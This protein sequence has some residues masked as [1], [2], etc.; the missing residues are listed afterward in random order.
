[1]NF[2]ISSPIIL[3]TKQGDWLHIALESSSGYEHSVFLYDEDLQGADLLPEDLFKRWQERSSEIKNLLLRIHSSCRFGDVFGGLSCDCGE[4]LRVAKE[5]IVSNK[6]GAI[7]YLDQEGRGAGLVLKNEAVHLEQTRNLKTSETFAHLGLGH[8]DLRNYDAVIYILSDVIHHPKDDILRM[9][10]N[11]PHKI[12]ALTSYGYKIH[13]EPIWVDITR[14][15][16]SYMGSKR[17]DM[18][19]IE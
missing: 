16:E 18:G 8:Q 12:E 1:M 13:R 9:M 14:H 2:K 5:L 11:N 7:F 10:T 6:R 17:A 19:H 3:P 15:A 4:Q